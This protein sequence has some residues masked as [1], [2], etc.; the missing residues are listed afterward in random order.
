MQNISPQSLQVVL[1]K[2]RVRVEDKVEAATNEDLREIIDLEVEE[3][4]EVLLV[5]SASAEANDK[6]A[7][8]S[9][10]FL[11]EVYKLSLDLLK[12]NG[13]MVVAYKDSAIS[14]IS[15]CEKY[16]RLTECRKLCEILRSH[17]NNIFRLQNSSS[18]SSLTYMMKFDEE[19]LK[20]LIPIREKLMEVCM[21]LN[22]WQEAFR[23]AEDTRLLICEGKPS[24]AVL[25]RYWFSLSR[26][27]W[28]AGQNLFHAYALYL[29]FYQNKK[30]NKKFS[31]DSLLANAIVLATLAVPTFNL[32]RDITGVISENILSQEINAKLSTLLIQSAMV[33]REQLIELLHTNN[34]L[35]LASKEIRDLFV[36]LENQ[37]LPLT[38][39]QLVKPLLAQIRQNQEFLIYVTPIEQL[40]VGRVLAQLST[41]YKSIRLDTLYKLIDF[42]DPDT[43]EKYIIEVSIKSSLKIRIDQST[44]AIF[45]E[46]QSEAQDKG[47]Q[48]S[49]IA[50][51]LFAVADKL[52]HKKNQQQRKEIVSR[53]FNDIEGILERSLEFRQSLTDDGKRIIKERDEM[54]RKKIEEDKKQKEFDKK[55]AEEEARQRE[56]TLKLTASLNEIQKERRNINLMIIKSV[57]EKMKNFG[58]SS[59]EMSINGKKL[60][61]MTDEEL[62]TAGP[63]ELIKLHSKLYEKSVKER[64]T[65]V[66]NLQKSLEYNE[67]AKREYMNP[68]IIEKWAESTQT[69]IETKKQLMQEKYDKDLALKKQFERIKSFKASY[70]AEQTQKA[71]VSFDEIFNAWYEKMKIHYKAEIINAAIK[72]REIEKKNK[73][74]EEKKAK[75][76]AERRFKADDNRRQETSSSNATW[77]N[78]EQ[79]KKTFTNSRIQDNAG[80]GL[81]RNF[82]RPP[83]VE[84]KKAEP[85][86]TPT[87]TPAPAAT[88]GPK[89][90][91][92]AKKKQEQE[93]DSE[94]F[95]KVG[96]QQKHS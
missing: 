16:Q 72:K 40:L 60:E 78:R 6:K 69:E 96:S 43:L 61:K 53:V 56:K 65:Q 50:E 20:N 77:R 48:I 55:K 25:A 28:K 1:E 31:A 95:T 51:S 74:E 27:F 41:C 57:V 37:F 66:K 36:L 3:A 83:V 71:R 68:L 88:G 4:P 9:M 46:D 12:T 5:A 90:F 32:G 73:E 7:I 76:E 49:K 84:E 89:R 39:S 91:F 45:F 21:K 54:Q 17:L 59:K 47:A 81:K 85:T 23:A 67:R 24:P 92:N 62:I 42:I 13:K 58:F 30:F 86:P 14:A 15:F 26:I 70:I 87:P 44:K 52:N 80:G 19:T 38:L 63:D 10:R 33:T 75:E 35:E 93:P 82:D 8:N 79:P 11:W 94:G 34:L 22:L 18:G 64:Q 2:L 29:Y